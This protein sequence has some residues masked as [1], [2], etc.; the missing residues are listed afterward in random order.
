MIGRRRPAKQR[1]TYGWATCSAYSAWRRRHAEQS[2]H[3][4]TRRR[5]ASRCGYRSDCASEV[6]VERLNRSPCLGNLACQ[7]GR[8]QEVVDRLG[9]V[10]QCRCKKKII[11]QPV[12]EVL[13]VVVERLVEDAAGNVDPDLGS[14]GSITLFRARL[15]QRA[16]RGKHESER[17]N[18]RSRQR[19]A[20]AS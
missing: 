3:R 4:V 1:G 15:D 9:C 14:G 19:R 17:R 5:R 11:G 6:L 16:K 12:L 7:C 10:K 18:I 2:R 13:L 20:D 8:R